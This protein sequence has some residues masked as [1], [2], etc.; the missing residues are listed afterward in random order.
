MQLNNYEKI[1]PNR[2]SP[3]PNNNRSQN[4]NETKLNDNDKINSGDDSQ[5][6]EYTEIT[7]SKY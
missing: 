3:N 2:S 4:I 6:Q 7:N 5:I 1:N